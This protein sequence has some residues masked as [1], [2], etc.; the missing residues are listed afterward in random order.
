MVADFTL[1][2]TSDQCKINHECSPMHLRHR[3][4]TLINHDKVIPFVNLFLAF[5]TKQSDKIA[6]KWQVTLSK[7]V[8]KSL[9]ADLYP[10]ALKW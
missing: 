2:E 1:L 4:F 10:S 3:L 6:I 9:W 5:S 7:D 8:W